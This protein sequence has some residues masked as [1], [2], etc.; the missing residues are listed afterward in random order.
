MTT[1]SAETGTERYEEQKTPAG[2][3]YFWNVFREPRDT[4]E[5]TD[6]WATAQGYV[7]VTPLRIGEFDRQTFEGWKDLTR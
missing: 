5:G 7:A 4:V 1:Q 6:V 3:C 2:R